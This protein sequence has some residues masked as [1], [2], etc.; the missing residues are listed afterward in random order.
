MGEDVDD[1][2][3]NTYDVNYKSGNTQSKF[4]DDE[5]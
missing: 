3:D 5:D 2:Y 1:D 4:E